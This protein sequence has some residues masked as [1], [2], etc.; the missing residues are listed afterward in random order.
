M[1]Q[2]NRKTND[3]KIVK[4]CLLILI[5]LFIIIASLISIFHKNTNNEINWFAF[6][7]LA[8]G[9]LMLWGEI[10]IF[11]NPN[12]LEEEKKEDDYNEHLNY[13]FPQWWCRLLSFIVDLIVLLIFYYI[14]TYI[15]YKSNLYYYNKRTIYWICSV[16][17]YYIA[18]EYGLQMSIGKL[19]FGLKIVDKRSFNKPKINQI[20]IRT[21]VRFLPFEA[22]TFLSIK[23]GFLPMGGLH[24]TLSNTY[25]VK[26]SSIWKKN[27]KMIF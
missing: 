7:G 25:V 18:F 14:I 27:T 10:K 24:D 16:I 22:L 3:P 11:K 6:I 15:M 5:S 12:I 19:I 1:E 21:L 2:N 9:G 8:I 23:K 4:N 26:K 13:A 17:A 20:L